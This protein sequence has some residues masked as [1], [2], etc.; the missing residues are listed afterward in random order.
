MHSMK[1]L[2]AKNDSG[3]NSRCLIDGLTIAYFGRE[4]KPVDVRF[5]ESLISILANVPDLR[6]ERI[7]DFQRRSAHL[8]LFSISLQNNTPTSVL[9]AVATSAG[10]TTASGFAEAYW[11]R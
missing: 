2:S 10:P 3:K 5:D 1:G 7:S 11:V 8:R 4:V 6:L 9:I